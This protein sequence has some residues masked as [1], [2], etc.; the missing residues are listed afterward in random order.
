LKG[1]LE[2]LNDEMRRRLA[3]KDGIIRDEKANVKQL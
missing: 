2:A 3:D 1:E